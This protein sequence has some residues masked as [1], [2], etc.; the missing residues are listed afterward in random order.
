M[1]L[2]EPH[3]RVIVDG[4]VSY[5]PAGSAGVITPIACHAVAWCGDACE[6]FHVHLALCGSVKLFVA[7]HQSPLPMKLVV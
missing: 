5:L 3:A 7:L 1:H 6:L 4:H 2:H